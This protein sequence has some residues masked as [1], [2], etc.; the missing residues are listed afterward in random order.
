MRAE[1]RA[2][3]VVG[4][5]DVGHPIAHGFADGVLEGAAAGGNA[6]HL[7]PQ[8]AHA[9][10][11]QALAAHVLR[12]HVDH[13]FEAQKGAHRSGGHAVLAGAGFGDDAALAHAARHQR[14]AQAVVDLV[15]A[16][17]Q[18]VFA[19]EVD[20]GAAQLPGKASGEP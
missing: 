11:I 4:I 17:V 1:G 5:G 16:G 12:T 10:N 20:A 14:L 8:Q 2:E 6:G 18:Q 15:R 19:L 9:E 13:A 7:G 3:Q